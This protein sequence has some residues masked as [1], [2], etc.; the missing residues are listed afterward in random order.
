M[1][2][3]HNKIKVL[4]FSNTPA[5]SDE[6][7]NR[8]LSGTGGWLKSL[9]RAVQDKVDLH[10]AFYHN[11]NS[12]SFRYG[13]TQYYPIPRFNNLFDK[14]KQKAF[15]EVIDT[16]H[17]PVYLD[18]INRINPDIIHIH[19]TENPFGCIVENTDVPV[20]VS[21]QGNMT[22]YLYKYCSGIESKYLRVR[23][24]HNP[25]IKS[26]LFPKSF[27]NHRNTF[28][29]MQLREEKNL[30][31]CKY[32]IGRTDWDRR[33]SRVLAP[34][35]DYFRNDE[36]L[37]DNFYYSEWT[38][39]QRQKLLLHTTNNNTFYK[40]FET[41]CL[42]LHELNK[43]GVYC[44]WRVAGIS[45][46]DLIVKVV[47]KKLKNS[48]PN[49]NLKLLGRLVGDDL[50]K[51][52]LEA[53]IYVMPSHIENSPNNLC[54]AMILGMPCIATF[55][56]GTGSLLRDGHEGILIQ[57]GDPWAMAGATLELRENYERAVVL[58]R[59]ARQSALKRHDKEKITND[60]IRT[61]DTILTKC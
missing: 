61:Y 30:K 47:K 43:L 42:A 32:I 31:N 58:G 5:N 1:N 12:D 51:K 35:R 36:I 22:V 40:G 14:L 49:K 28:I 55:A 44:E 33:I 60:L 10:I 39:K 4:W 7:F 52:M 25:D 54:E 38:P 11:Q 15:N 21:I 59:N 50:I 18:L 23:G 56:G 8:E 2:E 16:E 3:V 37:R 13:S 27:K 29:K 57:D 20:V 48:F 26:L 17:L 9:D 41:I 6:Y 46:N 24:V 53:D 19:G 34:E 45:Y